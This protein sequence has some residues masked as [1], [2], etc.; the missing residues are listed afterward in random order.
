MPAKGLLVTKLCLA[1]AAASGAVGCSGDPDPQPPLDATSETGPSGACSAV[2]RSY[3]GATATHYGSCTD[4]VYSTSPPVF[5]DHYP[6]W[7]AYETYDFPVPLG[8]LVHDLEHG[9]VVIFYDCPDGCSDEVD[10]ARAFI[11]ALPD[12]PRCTPDVRVQVVLVPR[13]GLGSR[14]AASAWG[15]ALTADCFDPEAFGN[16]YVE[17][18]AHGP[19][20]LCNQGTFFTSDPCK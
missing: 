15:N 1:L 20:D 4:I 6:E 10:A 12:D 11:D 7:A 16:F 8:F 18:H 2:V 17:H 5:G 9:A 3:E 13:P 14:W 19:E